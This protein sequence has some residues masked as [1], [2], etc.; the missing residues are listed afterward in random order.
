MELAQEC[1]LFRT[2]RAER[3][4]RHR[5][6]IAASLPLGRFIFVRDSN[7]SKIG[8]GPALAPSSGVPLNGTTHAVPPAVLDNWNTVNYA[9]PPVQAFPAEASLLANELRRVHG[10]NLQR[11]LQ[12]TPRSYGVIG[13]LIGAAQD[14]ILTPTRR[15]QLQ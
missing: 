9:T 15:V 13:P 10:K 1:W 2:G 12:G 6:K 7:A 14:S 4:R 5:K 11:R 8:V 3:R